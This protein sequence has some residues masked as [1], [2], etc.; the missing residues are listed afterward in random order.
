MESLKL[1]SLLVAIIYCFQDGSEVICIKRE[2]TDTQQQQQQ[3]QN[4]NVAISVT[5]IQAEEEVMC[6]SL[7]PMLP[8]F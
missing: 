6:I 7:H 2:A 8:G 4:S 5:E 1:K 3:Q